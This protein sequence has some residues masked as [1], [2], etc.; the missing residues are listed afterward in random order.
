M[1]QRALENLQNYRQQ[2][3]DRLEA[4]LASLAKKDPGAKL[5]FVKKTYAKEFSQMR[6][7]LSGALAVCIS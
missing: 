2:T 7:A 3:S 5:S 1:L 4:I 6:E